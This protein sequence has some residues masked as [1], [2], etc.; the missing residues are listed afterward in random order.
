MSREQE[1][2]IT[3][4]VEK[5]LLAFDTD[6]I[7]SENP[8]LWTRIRAEREERLHNRTK[9]IFM[10][11]GLRTAAVLLIFLI[12]LITIVYF[13]AP[14]EKEQTNATLASALK[15]EYQVEQSQNNF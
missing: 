1:Q 14:S 15:A 8:F 7:L 12:N 2:R 6:P 13:Y 10:Q 9:K 11:Y 3:E 4:E 5:T